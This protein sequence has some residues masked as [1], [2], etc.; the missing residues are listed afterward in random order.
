MVT[1]SI[2]QLILQIYI[3]H[4]K[5]DIFNVLSSSSIFYE[6]YKSPQIRSIITTTFSIIFGLIGICGS[7]AFYYGLYLIGQY[8]INTMVS[9][10]L[11]MVSIVFRWSVE[12]IG[13]YILLSI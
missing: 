13:Q 2:P 3:F 10:L 4:K 7:K 6:L 8:I 5:I 11:I 1:E 12:I 9:I